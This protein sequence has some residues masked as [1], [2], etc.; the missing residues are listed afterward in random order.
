MFRSYAAGFAAKEALSKAFHLG[1]GPG[2]D[3]VDLEINRND[4]GAPSVKLHHRAAD[5]A[6]QEA[7]G[8]IHVSLSHTDTHAIA[9]ALIES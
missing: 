2:F 9:C 6:R 8:P 4:A 3:W 1:I 7:L 5:L